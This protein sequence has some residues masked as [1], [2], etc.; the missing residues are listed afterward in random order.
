[1]GEFLAREGVCK[2]KINML[3]LLRETPREA[4]T[5]A[6]SKFVA[7]RV[8]D[9]EAEKVAELARLTRRSRSSVLRV[10]LQ[11]ARLEKEPDV[12]LTEEARNDEYREE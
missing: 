2:R 3:E 10:L 5:M 12:Q 11:Q 6:R 8:T 9:A 4:E 7:M 1:M